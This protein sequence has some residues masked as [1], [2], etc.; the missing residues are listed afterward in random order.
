MTTFKEAESFFQ[1][2]KS[3][4]NKNITKCDLKIQLLDEVVDQFE[5]CRKAYQATMHRLFSGSDDSDELPEVEP[6][7]SVSQV[8]ESVSKIS[9]TSCKML[10]RQI[11]VGRNAW[12]SKHSEKETGLWLKRTLPLPPLLLRRLKLTLNSWFKKQSMRQKKNMLRFRKAV[13]W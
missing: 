3:K 11:E 10:A 4:V 9:T 5:T 8:S 12:N 1:Y 2:F 13:R 7:D 6:E